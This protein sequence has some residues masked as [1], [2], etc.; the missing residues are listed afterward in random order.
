MKVAVDCVVRAADELGEC[1]VWD[2]RERLLWWVDIRAPAL[3]SYNPANGVVHAL[4]LGE[5]IGSF[6]LTRVGGM[7]A[8]M[9]SGLYLLDQ[10][11]GA[12]DLLAAPEKDSAAEPLQ[13]RPLRSRWP[14]LG[15]HHDRWPACTGRL[16][17]PAGSEWTLHAYAHRHQRPQQ[18][19]LESRR[20]HDVLRGYAHQPA[21]GVR[22]RS[23]AR[24]D[25]Q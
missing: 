9:K 12:L 15:R 8:G 23:R 10:F 24:H 4:A 22:L 18:H 6:G 13:R 2:D 11:S 5:F 19:R 3:K 21:V 17:V 1:T 16:A 20:S 14:L 7:V 25:A